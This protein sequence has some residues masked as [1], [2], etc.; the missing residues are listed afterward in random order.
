MA[1][2][3]E[4]KFLVSGDFEPFVYH[5]S[6]I[7]QGYL[8]SDPDRTVRIR[9]RDDRGFIT[10]K[11]RNDG[12]S[13]NQWEYEIPVADACEMLAACETGIDKTRCLIDAGDGLTWEV[14]VFAG[15]NSGLVV[16]EIELPGVDTP[17]A[18]PSWLGMEVTGDERYYN[19]SLAKAKG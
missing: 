7:A 19:S 14:D 13:R 4:R 3:I 18:R 10:V 17:F 12:C 8:C 11:T 2:E 9:V 6:H 15:A 5:R 16:A 1:K